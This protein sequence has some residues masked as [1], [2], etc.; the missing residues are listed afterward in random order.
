MTE[1]DF[2]D[3]DIKDTA[4]SFSFP[5]LDCSPGES[6]LPYHKDTQAA[7]WRETGG[8]PPNTAARAWKHIIQL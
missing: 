5:L 6:Q 8:L 2:C 4:A 1:C 3:E 7:L